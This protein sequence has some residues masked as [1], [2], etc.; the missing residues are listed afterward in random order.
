M[1]FYPH[2]DLKNT[3]YPVIFV[4]KENQN[5]KKNLF[6]YSLWMMHMPPETFHS[7]ET[8]NDNI[9]PFI[10]ELDLIRASLNSNPLQ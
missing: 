4:L 9:S 10:D 5:I 2:K 1:P 7:P 6:D 3:L 8:L